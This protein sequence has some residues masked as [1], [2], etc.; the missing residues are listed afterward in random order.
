MADH[1]PHVFA[2]ADHAFRWAAKTG[3]KDLMVYVLDNG[4]PVN[5][6]ALLSSV[7]VKGNPEAIRLLERQ[8]AVTDPWH[9]FTNPLHTA[10][11]YGRLDV[12][13]Y[14][15]GNARTM[16]IWKILRSYDYRGETALHK[17]IGGR[18][19]K[20]AEVRVIL[21]NKLLDRG[22]D[23]IQRDMRGRTALLLAR[24]LNYNEIIPALKA[25]SKRMKYPVAILEEAFSE[26]AIMEPPAGI[27]L[28]SSSSDDEV[29]SLQSEV[30]F[31]HETRNGS[32]KAEK[33]HERKRSRWRSLLSP[34]AHLKRRKQMGADTLVGDPPLRRDRQLEF[35]LN[36]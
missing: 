5:I 13:D 2:L 33:M 23:P 6:N 29:S 9:V 16:D 14:V 35:S 7:E 3:S 30:F 27:T 24:D 15:M 17:A 28:A 8:R 26:I 4:A 32:N 10:C 36:K 31:G 1:Y 20:K 34:E 12:A 22:A 25:A 18:G 11:F 19:E 21:I